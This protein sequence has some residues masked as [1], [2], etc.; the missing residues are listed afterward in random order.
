[1]ANYKT[2][3]NN[4]FRNG[5]YMFPEQSCRF[6]AKLF[7]SFLPLVNG[8]HVLFLP[9]VVL[10]MASISRGRSTK[11]WPVAIGQDLLLESIIIGLK[12]NNIIKLYM[13][14]S[15][16]WYHILIHFMKSESLVFPLTTVTLV[17]LRACWYKH[18]L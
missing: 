12:N 8:D 16:T 9:V 11:P 10:V 6:K 17:S 1:M 7:L 4:V 18:F 15:W 13:S 2:K 3:L 5:S 14:L